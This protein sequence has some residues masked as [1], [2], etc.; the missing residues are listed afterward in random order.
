MVLGS[1]EEA[2][3]D[4]SGDESASTET[5]RHREATENSGEGGEELTTKAQRHEEEERKGEVTKAGDSESLGL[6]LDLHVH[7]DASAD[8]R[9]TPEELIATVKTAGLHGLAITDHN[10]VGNQKRL[11]ELAEAEGLLVIPGVEITSKDGHVLAYGIDKQMPK[12]LPSSQVVTMVQKSGGLA[13]AAHPFRPV[14]GVGPR[15]SMGIQFDG[16]ET[17]NGHSTPKANSKAGKVALSIIKARRRPSL[18]SKVSAQESGQDDV[19]TEKQRDGEATEGSKKGRKENTM[20]K[21]RALEDEFP[22]CMTGGSDAHIA[23]RVGL[24]WTEFPGL[25]PGKATVEEVLEALRKGLCFPAGSSSKKMALD[26]QLQVV[27]N[28][29]KRGFRRV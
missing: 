11:K 28:R 20:G 10:E 17:L 29:I 23:K 18:R 1:A 4:V 13:V 6:R 7:S 15:L 14:T 9:T 2:M 19:T 27:K 5:L 26:Y 24:A 22:I 16:I 3:D 8:S 12:G 21:N 25:E